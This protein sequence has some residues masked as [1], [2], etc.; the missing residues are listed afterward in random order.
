VGRGGSDASSRGVRW[1]S[2]KLAVSVSIYTDER[3]QG[4]YSFPIFIPSTVTL[5]YVK[6][7][8]SA[9][10]PID[11][12]VTN[13]S[14]ASKRPQWKYQEYTTGSCVLQDPGNLFHW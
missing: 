10:E 2:S 13:A 9:S 7:S 4:T 5:F 3:A 12:D 6:M 14:T 11:L 8:N 1:I